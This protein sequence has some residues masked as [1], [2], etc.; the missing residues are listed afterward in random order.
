MPNEHFS[1]YIMRNKLHPT[2]F[3]LGF[4]TVPMIFLVDFDWCLT[5]TLAVFQPYCG[6]KKFAK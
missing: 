4:E 1:S 2:L 3:L 6:V 5:P